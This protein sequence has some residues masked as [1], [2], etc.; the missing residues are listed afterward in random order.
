MLNPACRRRGSTG[1]G[2][3]PRTLENLGRPGAA[4]CHRR[5]GGR[6]RT[7]GGRPYRHSVVDE[8]VTRAVRTASGSRNTLDLMDIREASRGAL[9]RSGVE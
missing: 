5:R 7:A 1:L 8:G 2:D 6:D 9:Y 4:G 3:A